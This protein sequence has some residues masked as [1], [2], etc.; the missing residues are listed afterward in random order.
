MNIQDKEHL[1]RV[2]RIATAAMSA[3]ISGAMASG[4]TMNQI[5][6]M[7]IT[8]RAMQFADIMIAQMDIRK[9][10]REAWR[11]ANADAKT[12]QQATRMG[13]SDEADF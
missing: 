3:I 7:D 1:E 2:E 9:A 11:E 4:K 8:D 6:T 12:L 10:E 13:L 5:K